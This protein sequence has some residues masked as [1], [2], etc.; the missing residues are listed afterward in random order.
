MFQ[1]LAVC[2][3]VPGHLAMNVVITVHVW[4]CELVVAA[5]LSIISAASANQKITKL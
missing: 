4:F 1:Q 5:G 2:G 3:A